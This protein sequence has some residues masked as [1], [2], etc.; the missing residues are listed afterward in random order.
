LTVSFGFS[1]EKRELVELVR[2][3]DCTYLELVGEVFAKVLRGLYSMMILDNGSYAF[4]VLGEL[5]DVTGHYWG[6][7]VPVVR[8][9]MRPLE[10][11]TI[12]QFF[13]D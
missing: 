9:V 4:H 3:F 10:C 5:D 2:Q 12:V 8:V 13:I 6:D 7:V 11:Q 1:V